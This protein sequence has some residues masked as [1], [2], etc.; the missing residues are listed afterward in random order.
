MRQ[1]LDD[2][3]GFAELFAA[4]ALPTKFGPKVQK[5]FGLLR[6]IFEEVLRDKI[7]SRPLVSNSKDLLDFLRYRI[8]Q[9]DVEVLLALFLSSNNRLLSD[10]ILSRGTVNEMAVF[11]REVLKHAIRADATALILVHNHPSGNPL[12]SE[13]DI[14]VTLDIRAICEVAGISLHDHLIVTES[15]MFSFRQEG[16]L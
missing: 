14:H 12:P 6:P 11:P 7:S 13:S 1:L 2:F 3:G 8:G 10:M 15:A 5:L 16:I 9:E 4:D